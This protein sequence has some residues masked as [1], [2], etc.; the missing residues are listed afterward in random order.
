M[1]VRKRPAHV[2]QPGEV[3]FDA[4]VQAVARALVVIGAVGSARRARA[5]VRDGQH[6]G[7]VALAES[8]DLL[9]QARDLHVGVVEEP[10]KHLFEPRG[11]AL[12]V[13]AQLI[14]RLHTAIARREALVPG[15][16]PRSLLPR[17]D[18]RSRRVPAVVEPA[19]V[20]VGVGPGHM[21]GGVPSGER[22]VQEERLVRRCR[23]QLPQ[24][25]VGVVDDAFRQVVAIA[26]RLDT[27]VAEDQFRAPLVGLAGQEAV[28]PVEAP[29]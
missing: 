19:P 11:K 16:Q 24:P 14:P 18:S 12:L 4:A 17:E 20:L 25:L 7:V 29:L 22:H 8:V 1:V 10:G 21:V 3:G 27:L 28:E 15:Q 5:V 26:R 2:V 13:G 23:H 6:D 9:E